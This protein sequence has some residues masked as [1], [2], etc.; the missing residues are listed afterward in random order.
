MLSCLALEDLFCKGPVD[1]GNFLLLMD[2][3]QERES[4]QLAVRYVGRHQLNLCQTLQRLLFDKEKTETMLRLSPAVKRKS[5]V[6]VSKL[7]NKFT[8]TVAEMKSTMDMK[9]QLH[10]RLESL[11]LCSRS[12]TQASPRLTSQQRKDGEKEAHDIWMP[13]RRYE[14]SLQCYGFNLV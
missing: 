6:L 5:A 4:L 12:G 9:C 7:M 13:G 10:T 8:Q 14:I 1:K 11:D 3:I 2:H